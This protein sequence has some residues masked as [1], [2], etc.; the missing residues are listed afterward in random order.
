MQCKFE[1]LHRN[2]TPAECPTEL[3][4]HGTVCDSAAVCQAVTN[5]QVTCHCLFNCHRHTNLHPLCLTVTTTPVICHCVQLSPKGS[6][7]LISPT[8]VVSEMLQLS[9]DM[10]KMR[11][12]M[13]Q[14]DHRKTFLTIVT[15]LIE[16]SPVCGAGS[17]GWGEGG[18]IL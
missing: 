8:A 4:H 16:K 3:M 10:V 5:T 17:L 11:V 14:Q 7:Y 13:M 1:V 12:G 2:L 6:P 15:A 9:V 18:E